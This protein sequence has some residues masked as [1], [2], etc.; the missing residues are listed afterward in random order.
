MS[1][2]ILR[3]C[4]HSAAVLAAV[5]LAGVSPARAGTSAAGPGPGPVMEVDF[6]DPD[7]VRAG[8]VYHAYATS[9]NGRNVQR[10]T[11]RDLVHWSPAAGDALPVLGAWVHPDEPRVWAP[12]VFANGRG[13]TLYYTAHDRASGRQCIG[14]ALSAG[15]Q[16]PFRP[17][18]DKPLICPVEQGG[19]IDAA[20]Y[21]EGGR[22]YV[23]W[24][25]DGNC[26]G[27]GTWLQMQS[28]SRDGTRVEGEPVRLLTPD[29]DWEGELVEAPTLIQRGHQYVLPYSAGPYRT[30]AYS[31]GYAVADR[32]T[33]PYVK[34]AAPLLTTDTFAGTVRGPGGQ[35]VVAGR[36]GRDRIVF[37]GWSADR[38]RRV[39]YAAQL[40]FQD[41][42]LSVGDGPAVGR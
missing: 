16:G 41:G 42:R 26:C 23:V 2:G 36:D 39:M 22:R 13:F 10:A 33:G 6:P 31:T 8:G 7:V 28:V 24:K 38:S 1:Y 35:D 40:T 17:V 12:E 19:A 18:G 14:V 30:D 25:N 27:I 9:G 20:S 37:H 29:H 4:L 5:A 15:T 3:R 21:T 32:L 11:S 34:A